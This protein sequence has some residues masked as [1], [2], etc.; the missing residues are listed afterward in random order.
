[1]IVRGQN[2]SWP[3]VHIRSLHARIVRLIHESE[4]GVTSA[5]L[6]TLL[7]GPNSKTSVRPELTKL[8]RLLG[9]LFAPHQT[10]GSY[11]F[12]DHV[13]MDIAPER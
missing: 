8:R 2:V 12:A 10:G 1:M 13:V 6:T 3:V 11:R 7:Y 4:N 5:E 9:S